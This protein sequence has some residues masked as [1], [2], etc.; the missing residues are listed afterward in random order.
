MLQ[1]CPGLVAST[2]LVRLQRGLIALLVG[3]AWSV[4]VS[5]GAPAATTWT[6][7]ASGCDYSSIKSAIAAPTT[8]DSDTLAVAAGTYT[9]AGITVNKSLTLQGER[10][11]TTIVQAAATK[12][13]APDRVFTI[14]SGVTATLQ[15][16]TIRYGNTAGSGGGLEN[17]GTL[18]LTR[19]TVWA[20]KATYSGGGL[21]NSGMLTL[22]NSTI[23]GNTANSGAAGGGL[24]IFFGATRLTHSTISGNA[25]D[26]A[27]GLVNSGTLTLTHSIVARNQHGGDCRRN[28]NG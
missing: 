2:S 22:L 19:S 25:A 20:N 11:A 16:L 8:L 27:G 12:G 7:C 17:Q 10:A 6:V 1:T 24:Y 26:S 28:D 13:T 18:T 5:L 14:A 3:L 4:G 21:V 9:E 23:S 15:D